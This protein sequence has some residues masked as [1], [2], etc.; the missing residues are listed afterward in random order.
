MTRSMPFLVLIGSLVLI[1]QACGGGA[2]SSIEDIP[3]AYFEALRTNDADMIRQ[4][5]TEGAA[6]NALAIAKAGQSYEIELSDLKIIGIQDA[7]E[8]KKQIQVEYVT[9]FRPKGGG[10]VIDESKHKQL[11][12]LVKTGDRWLIDQVD[13][14]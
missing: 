5:T 8:S 13:D 3:G 9:E 7:G 1:C 12:H 10:N 6:Q 11:M 2:P 4:L 14:E